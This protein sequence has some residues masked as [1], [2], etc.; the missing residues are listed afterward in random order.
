MPRARRKT[1]AS[2]FITVRRTDSGRRSV[3]PHAA[4]RSSLS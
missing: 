4:W 3:V 2:A 1:M